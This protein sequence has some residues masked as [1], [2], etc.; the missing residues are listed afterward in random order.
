MKQA[1]TMPALSDTMNNGRLARWLKKPGDP[2][3][4]GEAIAEVETDKAIMEVE[5]FHDGFL[6]GPLAPVDQDLPIGDTIGYIADTAAEVGAPTASAPAASID[7]ASVKPAERPAPALAVTTAS[8]SPPQSA[9]SPILA[10]AQSHRPGGAMHAHAHPHAPPV[11][12]NEKVE[13]STARDN[14]QPAPVVTAAGGPAF[15]TEGPPYTLARASSLREAVARNMIAS[16]ATPT[17]RVTALLPLGSLV[18]MAKDKGVSL[19]LALARACAWAISSHPLLNAAYTDAGLAQRER[20][21]VAIAVDSQDGLITPVLRDVAKRPLSELSADWAQLREKVKTRRLAPSDYRGAT[22]YL[23]DLGVFSVVYA[24][25][26]VIPIGASAILSV[27]ATRDEGAFCTLSCD[28]RVVFGGD[29]ARFLQTLAEIV[30][31]PA[32]L[33]EDKVQ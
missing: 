29:A 13:I 28:H 27:A 24:F 4:S 26:S 11:A 22:F 1:V 3:K 17:F 21:D 31:A 23:S 8:A 10:A 15:L 25:D 6:A 16:A 14:S 18:A 7:N 5:A 12:A 20:V 9:L 32:K 30:S 33:F 19:S 2:V